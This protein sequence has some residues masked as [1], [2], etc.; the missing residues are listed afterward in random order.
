MG[1]RSIARQSAPRL[2]DIA[3]WLRLDD[4]RRSG[5]SL[6]AYCRIRGWCYGT[7]LA[8]Q[9]KLAD[10]DTQLAEFSYCVRSDCRTDLAVLGE[11]L[12]ANVLP[13]VPRCRAGRLGG[14]Q[15]ALLTKPALNLP[16]PMA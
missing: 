5:F 15:L 2:S 3:W 7:A 1:R 12:V 4:W 8:W 11:R 13:A 6:H 14:R 10:L 9:R 16:Y